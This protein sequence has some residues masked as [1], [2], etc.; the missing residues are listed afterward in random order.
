MKSVPTNGSDSPNSVLLR[1][2]AI[3]AGLATA[4]A[5]TIGYQLYST[6]MLQQRQRLLETLDSRAALLGSMGQFEQENSSA[7][8]GHD[9]LRAALARVTEG[10][11]GFES[12][13]Q[14]GR[15]TLARRQGGD[16][17]VVLG[18][19]AERATESGSAKDDSR[20]AEPMRRALSGERGTLIVSDRSGAAVIAAYRP[21]PDLGLGMVATIQ[22]SEARAPFMRTAVAGA[23]LSLVLVVAATA[24]FLRVGSPLV[25][26]LV[27]YD[28]RFRA[29][30]E[31][32]PTI[33][34]A[35]GID[36]GSPTLYVSPQIETLLGFPAYDWVSRP[37]LFAERLHPEDRDRVLAESR[38]ARGQGYSSSIEYR[39]LAS[40]GRV[41]W[42]R[43][44]AVV[45]S[46]ARG[47]PEA[48][49]GVMLDI[50]RRKVA[51][52]AARAS[53][54]RFRAIV[55]SAAEG[56][57]V[58]NR[59][60]VIVSHNRAAETLFGYSGKDLIG[61]PLESLMPQRYRGA[62]RRGLDA[63]DPNSTK[64]VGTVVELPGLRSDGSEFPLSLSLGSFEQAGEVFFSGL[65][66]DLTERRRREE[67]MA[68]LAAG[69]GQVGEA[70]IITDA[71]GIIVF[72]N[73]ALERVTG[74][75]VEEVIG[76]D[77]GA[78]ASA[79]DEGPLSA[80]LR[81]A[82]RAGVAWRGRVEN[83][84][85]DGTAYHEDAMV[86]P[87]HDAEGVI[88]NF[89][90]VMRD[91]SAE[92][93]LEERL[94]Q[95]QKMEAV[96][97]LAGGVAHDFNNLLASIAA[98][99]ELV[100]GEVDENGP[101]ADDLRSVLAVVDRG[102]D[103]TRQLTVFGR[104]EAMES[105]VL[106]LNELVAASVNLLG[107][108]VDESIEMVLVTDP[109]V[110]SVLGDGG[111]L[112][113]VL[114]NLVLNA[115]DAMSDG[116]T[117]RI[118][119]R[120]LRIGEDTLVPGVAFEGGGYAVV[121]VTD[122]GAGMDQ[123]TK[124]RVFEP[125]FTTKAPGKGSGFGLATAYGIV[126]LHGGTINVD[127]KLGVGTTF[128]VYLPQAETDG[129]EVAAAVPDPWLQDGVPGGNETVLLVEDEDEIRHLLQRYLSGCGYRVLAAARP[130][131]A[132]R[133][134]RGRD[135]EIALLLTDIVMPGYDGI[136]LYRRLVATDAQLK[137]VFISGYSDKTAEIRE[138]L[139]RGGSFLQ[140]PFSLPELARAVRQALD[141]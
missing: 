52:A 90:V 118:E 31:H 92:V 124:R 122:N 37:D 126:E 23:T 19:V 50:T 115:R 112:E 65:L 132:D 98:Y 39:M 106:D 121:T 84:R 57:L 46:N 96:G 17:V 97:L 81:A 89:V 32:S 64:M 51:E 48:V 63:F 128:S 141:A 78:M 25:A 7:E 61:L 134:H 45:L 68:R 103:L 13:G 110:G 104:R 18:A 133:L 82:I 2:L 109:S 30:V 77:P 12:F 33:T 107:R 114:T 43:D 47:E 135:N 53:D 29:F 86:S 44:E 117:L 38:R 88:S 1:L 119:T 95:A 6:S 123:E 127:S 129:S 102:S 34:Y 22:R 26:R 125:F 105:R 70:V 14:T 116:G 10:Y 55:E 20:G 94:R 69:I 36:A 9:A 11:S 75:G 67:A 136:T 60:G 80:E 66:R 15:I 93:T 62:H 79:D 111:R 40:D 56:V 4:V 76:R 108:L 91:V 28:R 5:L 58:A 120:T 3:M 139:S 85:K 140:K 74:Y 138:L 41:V 100:L 16:I 27:H 54:E 72:A 8:D 137:V 113:Q 49:H 99:S 83:R 42:F 35:A 59:D 21:L 87:V 73:P 71:A 24:L 131:A 130:E 101:L